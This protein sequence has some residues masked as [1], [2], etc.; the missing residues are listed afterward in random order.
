MR[1]LL[2][3]P[4]ALLAYWAG[5][6]AL[7][8][9]GPAPMPAIFPA[10]ALLYLEAKNFSGLVTDWNA[11]AEKAAW[12]ASSNYDAFEKSRL[13]LKLG[14]AQKEFAVAAG[15]PPD[16]AM[17][18]AVAGGGSAIAMYNIGDLHFLYATHLA[19]AR[20]MD[21]ALWKARGSFQT[22]RAGGVDYYVKIDA[23]SHRVAAFAYSGDLL[24]LATK[25]DLIAGALELAARVARP[26]VASEKWFQ[27]ATAAAGAPGELRLVYNLERLLETPHFRSYWV[28]R[29]ATRLSEFSAGA[30][31]LDRVRGEFRERRVLLRTNAAAAVTDESPTGQLMAMVPDDAG[32]YRATL[33]PSVENVARWISGRF[34]SA[35]AGVAPQ[36]KEAPAVEN[37]AQAGTES[38]LE[39]RID[40]APLN[41]DRDAR[42]YRRVLAFFAAKKIDGMLEVSRSVVDP[43]Q[44]FVGLQ[45]AL[46]VLSDSWSAFPDL[47]LA[48]A[49]R[50]RVLIVGNSQELVDAIARRAGASPA[51]GAVYAAGWR[52]ARELSN[53]EK[54]TRLID[55]PQAPPGDAHEPMFF[56]ENMA[57]LGGVLRRVL[58]AEVTMHDA[59]SM[60]RETVLYRVAP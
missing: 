10:G 22:R 56:S 1:R 55:F 12:L 50:G 17:L 14:E 23:Q 47:D 4:V 8:Q 35:S 2:Y 18:G 30:A 13:F 57:S 46:V 26:P 36:S 40:L 6:W 39:T 45:S 60:L 21:T 38:D 41:D 58:S 29:N 3:L 37:T 51:A 16:Y 52:H 44:V 48:T 9:T 28:Q 31:D 7:G 5:F 24:L 19:S 54:L 43:D 32:F 15:V 53:F 34:L 42:D 25:E 49:V 20:A 59:G 27:D 33:R 11:S